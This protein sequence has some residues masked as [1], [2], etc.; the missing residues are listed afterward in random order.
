MVAPVA[1]PALPIENPRYGGVRYAVYR[2]RVDRAVIHFLGLPE[3]RRDLKRVAADAF[4]NV[5]TLRGAVTAE[6]RRRRQIEA[7][8][9]SRMPAFIVSP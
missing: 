5:D 2:Q 8:L 9:G 6:L 1:S 7:R 3:D 4:V